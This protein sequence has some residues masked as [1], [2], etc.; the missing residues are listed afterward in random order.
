MG[1]YPQALPAGIPSQIV[2]CPPRR[3]DAPPPGPQPVRSRGRSE[4]PERPLLRAWRV[5]GL[6]RDLEVELAGA[7]RAPDPQPDRQDHFRTAGT[8]DVTEVD[9]VAVAE[10]LE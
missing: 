10:A 4:L 1:C 3:P 8:G 6:A 5:K 9:H 7:Q 2:S